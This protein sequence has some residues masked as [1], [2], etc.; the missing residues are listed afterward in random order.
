M[1]KIPGDV[2]VMFCNKGGLSQDVQNLVFGIK[3]VPI[4]LD[5][6]V[7]VKNYFQFRTQNNGFE[8]GTVIF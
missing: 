2:I 4:N 8:I 1:T 5:L 6:M 3:S 7:G